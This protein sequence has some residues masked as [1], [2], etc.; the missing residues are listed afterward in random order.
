MLCYKEQGQT[1]ISVCR[2][3]QISID[4]YVYQLVPVLKLF[5]KAG[6]NAQASDFRW[7]HHVVCPAEGS[8]LLNW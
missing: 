4:V 3:Y 5:F 6:Q 7:C 8:P 1:D 2:Y